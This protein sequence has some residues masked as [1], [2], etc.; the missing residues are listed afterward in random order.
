MGRWG[1]KQ[2]APKWMCG[3]GGD[4]AGRVKAKQII[5][6]FFCKLHSISLISNKFLPF[7]KTLT[8]TF[9]TFIFPRP[10][11]SNRLIS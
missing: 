2:G 6:S 9:Y 1:I 8:Y 7:E 4:C 10:H 11:Y 5:S 3:N